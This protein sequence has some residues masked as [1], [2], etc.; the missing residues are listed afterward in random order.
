MPNYAAGLLAVLLMAGCAGSPSTSPAPAAPA[1]A[2]QVP[3]ACA[4]ARMRFKTL[5]SSPGL[6]SNVVTPNAGCLG[7]NDDVHR[8]CD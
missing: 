1:G 3:P 8:Y 4:A 6:P 5:C 7:A 2:D